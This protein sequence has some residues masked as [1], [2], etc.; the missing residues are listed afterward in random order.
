MFKTA[1]YF[2]ALGLLLCVVTGSTALAQYPDK[3]IRFIVPYAAG[4]SPDAI[5]R[6]I[7]RKSVV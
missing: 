5:C 3:P 7:D 4:S 2:K 6:L 1:T